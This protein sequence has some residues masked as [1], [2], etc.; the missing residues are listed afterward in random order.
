MASHKELTVSC[1]CG[2]ASHTFSVP[3]SKLPLPTNLCS[4]NISRRISG[5]LLT[6]YVN[7]TFDPDAPN[8]D[9]S[10]LTPYESSNI[11]T[12]YFCSTCGTHMYLHY[13][14]DGHFEVATGTFQ[15]D[16][17]DGIIDFRSHMWI[18]DTIDGGASPFITEIGDRT[19]NRYPQEA[20]PS[21]ELSLTWR[22]EPKSTA[23]DN[24]D[25]LH[26]HC[27]CR[28]VE[29]WI[30]RPTQESRNTKARYSDLVKPYHSED[31]ENPS[32]ETWFLP[33]SNRF[34][35][36]TCACKSCRLALGFDITT[37][38][39]VP[40]TNISLDREGAKPFQRHPY[41]GTMKA[42]LLPDGITRTFCGVCG[43][44][45]FWDGWSKDGS[46][47]L[48]DVAVGLLDARTGARAEEWLAWW[49]NRVSFEEDALNKGL[50]AGLKKGL[51]SWAERNEG[52]DFVATTYK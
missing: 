30:S 51:K 9:L 46:P 39:F 6:S 24:E 7:I 44:N 52:E 4:C 14:K 11:L 17:T 23:Q 41:W 20:K 26:A 27:H 33:R 5:T 34:M 37:W 31:S 45:V 40:V 15:L 47:S 16:S 42:H 25:K 50:I 8:P 3:T 18:E 10:D 22:D 32:N 12:R 21:V 35:A 13:K 19:L 28:G 43:A 38:A 49:P 2:A 48:I 36:G 1:K 29:F